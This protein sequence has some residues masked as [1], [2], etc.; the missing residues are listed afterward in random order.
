VPFYVAAPLTTIDPGAASGADIPI[1]E[2]SPDEVLLVEGAGASGAPSRVRVAPEDTRA[3][4][5]AFDVTPHDLIAGIVT[6]VGIVPA[7]TAGIAG[8][9][10]RAARRNETAPKS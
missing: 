8:A 7:T 4:N 6:P 5:P 10:E 1:E 3:L 9:L 2:R